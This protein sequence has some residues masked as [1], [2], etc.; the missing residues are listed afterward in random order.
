MRL[1]S[2]PAFTVWGKRT[3]ISGQ[4]NEQFGRFWDEAKRNGLLEL[5]TSTRGQRPGPV[6]NSCTLGV[7]CVEQDPD[8][9]AFD[10][11]I[12]AEIQD[13]PSV[14]ENDLER[15]EVPACQWA[16]FEGQGELPMSLVNAEM[17]C[18]LR[19]LPNSGYH[20]AAAPELEIYPTDDT[21]EFW[22]PVEPNE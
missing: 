21:V 2:K 16:I 14:P 17:D 6:T 8:N 18:F 12:A 7:S 1:E 15:H 10:F 13:L 9:R 19:W 3:W 20:H 5:L 22:L 11:F 4:D